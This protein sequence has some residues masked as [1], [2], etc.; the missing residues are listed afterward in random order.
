M[1]TDRQVRLLRSKR[2]EDQTLEAA[3]AAAGMSE[4]AARKW[5]RGAMPSATKKDRSWR[6]RPDPF[7]EVWQ[8][9]VEPLLIGD[10]DGELQATTVIDQLM[11]RYPGRFEHGQVRTL[12]RHIRRWR[13]MHG[14][15]KEVFFPQEQQPGYLGA[16]D[17]THCTE[18]KV[19]IAGAAF[20]HL[21]FQ[22][23]MAWSGWRHVALAFGET[24]EALVSGLQGALWSLGG[25]PR[26]IRLDNMSAATHE[27]VATGGRT[28]TRR[29]AHVVDHYDFEASRI[30]PHEAHQNGVVEK[31]N[32]LFKTA[33]RQALILRG[34]RDFP[35]VDAYLAFVHDVVERRFHR[36]REAAISQER[37]ALAPLPPHR[38]A[39]Y[40]RVSAKVRKWSTVHVAGRVYSVPSRLI[41]HEVDARVHPDVVEIWLGGSLLETMP[42]L[43]GDQNHR[44]DYRHVI[45]SL[46][47]KPGAFAA[48]RY[49]E[50]LFPTMTFRRAYDALRAGRGDRAD[51]E[52]VRI[53]H[54]AASTSEHL[55]EQAVAALL[56]Q[57]VPFDFAAVK[58]LAQ[59]AETEVPLVEFTAPDL[60]DYDH[61]IVLTGDAA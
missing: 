50:D 47:R 48:Y 7:A 54:L 46:V 8:S 38:L 25:V 59:P 16:M 9:D 53:L 14:P 40:T 58:A 11:T 12:Q 33:L 43:R 13:A 21:M 51:V 34:H 2:M 41:G 20:V 15:Q 10:A 24:Y 17:F 61:L 37:A 19:T 30:E 57:G 3:A 26:R 60:R 32:D 49:R 5:Q 56:D 23:V 4:R 29:F 31:A 28:L 6:T 44:I 36:G 55:V 1:V 39:E 42:R 45:W 18:L 22:F 52:Y 27:L 35:T